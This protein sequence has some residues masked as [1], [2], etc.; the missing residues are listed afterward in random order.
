MNQHRNTSERLF[1]VWDLD[2]Q[3]WWEPG[4]STKRLNGLW[5]RK[6]DATSAIKN[7]SV[8]ACLYTP[9]NYEIVEF[10]LA[11]VWK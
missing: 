11:E 5:K 2:K 6:G 9:K 7:N 4:S 3:E 10:Q 8:Y 1:K